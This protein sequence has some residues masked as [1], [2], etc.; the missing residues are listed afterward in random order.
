MLNDAVRNES[1]YRAISKK[2]ENNF[3]TVLDIGTGTGLLSIYARKAGATSI[4]SCD[5]SPTMISIADKVLKA[6]HLK[7]SIVLIN[8]LSNELS[9]PEDVPHR[10]SLA[11]TETFDGGLLGEHILQTLIHAWDN[12]LE[13]KI[14]ENGEIFHRVIPHGATLFITPIESLDVARKNYILLSNRIKRCSFTEGL[15]LSLLQSFAFS[16][17]PY[18][19]ENLK[20]LVF[21][22]LGPTLQ[23]FEFDF[24]NVSQLKRFYSGD[25]E[26]RLEIESSDVGF[27]DALVVWFDLMLDEEITV[28][29]SPLSKNRCCWEQAI[30]PMKKQS[31]ISNKCSISISAS[32]KDGILSVKTDTNSNGNSTICLP[33]PVIRFLNC[34]TLLLAYIQLLKHIKDVYNEILLLDL[35]WFPYFSLLASKYFNGTIHSSSQHLEDLDVIIKSLGSNINKNKIKHQEWS[36]MLTHI[37]QP[38]IKYDIILLDILT[39]A[40]E[41]DEEVI[42]L[43]P[44]LRNLLTPNGL[45]LPS[46]LTIHC[47]L[48]FSEELANLSLMNSGKDDLKIAEYINEYKV[49]H[50]VDFKLEELAFQEMSACFDIAVLDMNNIINEPYLFEKELE[51]DKTGCINSVLYW[52]S[53]N[54]NP[55]ISFST[56]SPDSHINQAAMLLDDAVNIE[57]NMRIKLSL[58]YNSGAM[59]FVASSI[60]NL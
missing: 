30:F 36:E 51:I 47:M 14:N 59:K 27:F 1:Y 20:N 42:S 24:N 10:L 12:L 21:K 44:V 34:E 38:D 53:M 41:I 31:F 57:K 7:D 13:L 50:M 4:Y 19:T 25:Q 35:S 37:E 54:Y 60:K 45:L 46:K 9:V 3:K 5:Y 11:V 32:C 49:S 8:K 33:Q 18:D 48:V 40:G 2:I 29:S 56:R 43:V 23:L 16:T 39:T 6:N 55:E 17:E 15:D 22:S 52:F 28:T 26:K 58:Y